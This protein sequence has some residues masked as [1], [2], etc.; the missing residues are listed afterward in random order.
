[1]S[2]GRL[3][4][5]SPYA[6]EIAHFKSNSVRKACTE[7]Q[8]FLI[9]H[10]QHGRL[11]ILFPIPEPSWL[12]WSLT[13]PIHKDSLVSS[14]EWLRGI[15]RRHTSLGLAGSQGKPPYVGVET[16]QRCPGGLKVN[17]LERKEG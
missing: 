15:G 1:M 16:S 4:R 13:C 10:V 3:Q 7:A 2:C 12:R 6:L 9:D 8:G 14:H 17:Q 5:P 11:A